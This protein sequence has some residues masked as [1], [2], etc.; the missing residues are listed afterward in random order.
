LRLNI[1][2][3][4]EFA[5]RDALQHGVVVSDRCNAQLGMGFLDTFSR[6][7]GALCGGQSD[8][9]RQQHVS[10]VKCAAY[11]VQQQGLAC[12]AENLLVNSSSFLGAKRPQGHQ[13]HKQYVPIGTAASVKAD[14]HKLS[15]ADAAN[16]TVWSTGAGKNIHKELLPWFTSAFDTTDAEAVKAACQGYSH[17]VHHPVLF[18]TRLDTTNPYHHTQVRDFDGR[19]SVSSCNTAVAAGL[20]MLQGHQQ[21]RCLPWPHRSFNELSVNVV[22]NAVA[23][24][25]IPYTGSC[26]S[27]QCTPTPGELQLTRLNS[28][29]RCCGSA[30]HQHVTQTVILH[31]HQYIPSIAHTCDN[32]GSRTCVVAVQLL[33]SMWC[34]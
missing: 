20:C 5:E 27:E 1:T 10:S 17:I 15:P 9:T 2:S 21:V 32:P 28:V 18:V 3:W 12:W 7:R 23:H 13:D 16:G 8:H 19:V 11:P 26:T 22:S 29:T 4:L 30:C 24:P 34:R 25:G 14:C 33:M 6:S 31:H